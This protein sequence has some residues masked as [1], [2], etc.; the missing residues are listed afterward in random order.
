M[1]P[2]GHEGCSH[3]QAVRATRRRIR[4]PMR[5]GSLGSASAHGAMSVR[6]EDC[7]VDDLNV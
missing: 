3:I 1:R 5:Y 2:S 4:L 6:F 7:T